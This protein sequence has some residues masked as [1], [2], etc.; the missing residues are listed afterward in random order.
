MSAGDIH[1]N[2]WR[3]GIEISLTGA[4]SAH[5]FR[6][7]IA[8]VRG[9]GNTTWFNMGEKRPF[10]IR[11]DDARPMFGSS[12]SARDWTVIACAIDYSF[13]R[14]Y[15]AY[16]LG[17]MLAHQ[18][19]APAGH[20]VHVYLG[21]EYRGVY[22]ISDQMQ[23]GPGRADLASNLDPALSEYLLEWCARA[24][25]YSASGPPEEFFVIVDIP[26]NAN[27]QDIPFVVDF[28]GGGI[29][30]G[31]HGHMD[32]LRD[33][34]NE[35]S[36]AIRGGNQAE[37]SRLIDVPSFIDF[38]LVQ[39]LF[40]NHDS[41]WSSLRFQIKQVDGRPVLH[42]GPLWDFDISAGGGWSGSGNYSPS[43]FRAAA[44]NGWFNSLMRAP[45]F[46]QRAVAR[47]GEIRGREVRSMVSRIGEVSQRYLDCFERNFERWPV[48]GTNV[49]RP[50][51]TTDPNFG[52]TP[53][54][55][56]LDTFEENIDYLVGWLEQRIAWMNANLSVGPAA[57]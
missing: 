17:R 18:S 45:W 44:F 33:F 4:R 47:W 30:R 5:N 15:S 16:F 21:G 3:P 37:I 19:F 43:G 26:N 24:D 6:D 49:F 38:Y 35:V 41:F 53:S 42:A 8:Q 56:A 11:F 25:R 27:R 12:Y 48:L 39:E 14:Q 10:R 31:G 28:P 57:R 46:R 23:A 40:K 22:M 20:F 7:E 51:S 2:D 34:L 9:R 54:V 1:R 50:G 36:T 29:L 32:F 55:M 52:V 13:M